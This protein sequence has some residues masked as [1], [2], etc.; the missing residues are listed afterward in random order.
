MKK[1]S[2]ILTAA[3]CLAGLSAK[4]VDSLTMADFVY[5]NKLMVAGYTGSETL[6][7][8]PVL[9][10]IS[11]SLGDFQYSR[12][13][14]SKG[15]DLAF[16]AEDGTKLASEVDTWTTSG[17]SLVWV[18]LPSMSNGTKFYMCYRLTDELAA[19][20][21]M[22]EN[23]NPWDDYVG[24]WHLSE[25]GTTGIT[26]ADSSTNALDGLTSA[27]T[28]SG[29]T[30]GKIGRARK[31]T[32]NQSNTAGQPYESGITVN[33]DNA[34][35]MDAVDS[36]VPAFAASMWIRPLQS[37]SKW[38]Y[39]IA[40]RQGDK[41]PG[42]GVQFDLDS[43]AFSPLRIYAGA[44]TDNGNYS[45]KKQNDTASPYG[46][47]VTANSPGIAQNTWSK[48]DVVWKSDGT[49]VLYVNG[50]PVTSGNLANNSPP[51]NNGLAK[52]DI[53]GAPAVTNR[54]DKGGRGLYGEMDEVR[55]RPGVPSA[56]WVKAD[57]D[58]VNNASFVTVAPKDP[59]EVTWVNAEGAAPGVT[60]VGV[61]TV[62]VSGTVQNCGDFDT[63]EIQFKFWSTAESEPESWMTITNGLVSSDAFSVTVP[64]M[65]ALTTYNYKLRAV[66]DDGETASA[67]VSGSF[68]MLAG[69][70][71]AWSDAVPGAEG[72]STVGYNSV[73]VGGTVVAL[74]DATACEIQFKVWEDGGSEPA[75]WTTITNGL[76]ASDVF[77][78]VIPGL[79]P[80][81]TYNYSLRA[82]GN[83]EPAS[84]T[85]P[86]T[87]TF[88][89]AAGLTIAATVSNVSYVSA[90]LSGSVTALGGAT[91]CA[92]QYKVWISEDAE[93][94]WT[95]LAENLELNDVF[96]VSVTN[97][98]AGTTYSYK[99]R[100]VGDDEE[101]TEVVSGT[102]TTQ[103]EPG[104]VIGSDYTH[105]F[106]DGTN[107][108]WVAN[109]FE[110]YLQF[111][112]TGYE[113]SETLTNFPVLVEVRK[114]DT[115]GFSYD[116]FYRYDGSDMTFVD[117]KGHLIPHEIDTW[118]KN[119]MSLFWVR[120]PRMNNGTTFTMCY[121]SP[122]LDPIPYAGN[123]FEKYVGVWH[124]NET[125]DGVVD[126]VDATTNNLVG[127]SHAQS[128]AYGNGRIG[129][130]RQ[131]AQ[132]P[133]PSASNGRIIVFDKNDI[134][135][136]GVG[137][138]FTYSCWSKLCD[139]S[140]GWA[141][142]VSRKVDDYSVG[143]GVQYHDN[144]ESTKKLRVYSGENGKNN[145]DFFSIENIGYSHTSWSCWTFVFDGNGPF[146]PGT[147]G[148]FHAYYNGNELSSTVGGLPLRYSIV[149][150]ENA[151]F[152]HLVLGGQQNGTG[153]LNGYLDECRYS[154]GIRS[155][156]WIKAEYVSAMQ[157]AWW[158]DAEKRFVTK[159]A[160]VGRGEESLA[161]VVVWEKGHD[162][163]YAVVDVSYAYVQFSGTVT[164]CGAGASECRIEYQLWADG[165]E[166][167]T[168]WTTLLD[169]ATAGTSFSIPV[170]GL[171]QD[172]PYKFCVRAVN[173]VVP[174]VEQANREQIGYFR[175]NGN[176][177]EAAQGELLRVDNK[178]CHR[179]RAG[180]Y[181]F[182]TP[183]YVTNVEIMVVG[184]GGAG[185][186]KVGG[187]GGG[188]GLF[189]AESFPVA[190]NATYRIQVG[191]GGNAASN[192]TAR[193][194]NG[195]NSYFARLDVENN[196]TN[197][198]M[199]ILVPG[200]GS[201][202]SYSSTA[203]IA[204]GGDG[205][206]G[207][208]GTYAQ[209]G[210]SGDG[211]YGNDGGA[212]N[213]K[214][215]ASGKSKTA[216][217]GGGGAGRGGLMATSDNWWAGGA[218][219]VG[220]VC[221]MTGETL[222]Y[223][224]GGG[225][226]YQYYTDGAS[227]TRPG[228]GG[229][230]I[231]G[232]AANVRDGIL[233]TS[234]IDNTG[235]GGGGG[236]MTQGASG[237]EI[238][239]KGGDGGDG[240]VLV[241][242]EVHGRDPISEDPRIAMTRC[243]YTPTDDGDVGTGIATIDYRA[244]WAGIQ[245]SENDIYILYSTEGEDDVAA[246]NGERI[247][248][249]SGAIGTG[250]TTFVPPEAGYTYWIRLVA[251]KD[252]SSFMYSDE[253][254]SFYVPAVTLNGAAWKNNG[255]AQVN[256]KLH[257]G[258]P[259][260]HLYCY[261]SES[262]ELLEGDSEPSGEGVHFLDLGTDMTNSTSFV[263]AASEGLDKSEVYYVRL[264]AGDEGGWK[265]ALSAEI[266]ELADAPTVIL[267]N[268]S[269]S[270]QI[271]T[272]EFTANTTILPSETTE[273]F[274][275]YSTNVKN[276]N[277]DVVNKKN[278]PH[279]KGTPNVVLGN[280]SDLPEGEEASA[281]FPLWTDVA[282]NYYVRLAI[283]SAASNAWWYSDIKEITV[284]PAVQNQNTLYIYANAN[285]KKAAYGDALQTLDYE[286]TYGGLTN[287]V[288]WD[289]K[290]YVTG[291]LAC[292]V[293]ITTVPGTYDIT[294]G[295]LDIS[296]YEDY[297]DD[298][299]YYYV[300]SCVGAKYTVTNAVFSVDIPDIV[301][302]YTGEAFDPG[303]IV[304]VLT[305][306]RNNQ[307]VTC[308]YRIGSDPWSSTIETSY[309]DAC[310]R[311][312]QF[313]AT[314]PCHEEASGTF[315]ITINPAPLSATISAEGW[316]YTGEPRAP[317]V[318]TN[319]TGL[320][321]G[322]LNPL[323]C[324]FRD[325]GGAWQSSVPSSFVQPGEYT[326]YF[327]VSASNHVTFVT[328]CTFKITGWEYKVNMDG[329][330]GLENA[331]DINVSDPGWLLRA[332]GITG[333]A[334]AEDVYGNLNAV[335]PNGLKLWQNYVIERNDLSEMLVA[336]I[337]QNCLR[338]A[339]NC[340][341]LRF[342]DA[343]ALRNTGLAVKFRVDQK[344]KGDGEF[345]EGAL[346]DKYEVNVPLGPHDPTGLYVFNMVF[347]PTNELYS[348]Q[349]SVISS[350]ATVGVMRVSSPLPNAVVA[351]PWRSMA[352][353]T[354][355]KVNVAAGDAVNPNG[356]TTGDMI[357]SYNQATTNFN[358]W[359]IGSDGAWN[360]LATVNKGGVSIA[361]P[362]NTFF[363]LGSAF[364]LV[365]SEPT[366][367][368]ATNCFYLIGRYTG[369][370]YEVPLAGGT[371]ESPGNTL[372]ANPT[373]EDIDL[374]DLAFTGSIAAGDRIVMQ[375]VAGAQ[376]TYTR[377][378]DKWGRKVMETYRGRLRQKWVE[379]GTNT[380]G[381]GFWYIRTSNEPLTIS[382]GGAK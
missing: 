263:I 276:V 233:A 13:R 300:F 103:G 380:V 15:G 284:E 175:T 121:R 170:T 352:Y 187:G 133:G 140:P 34:A 118:N 321:R 368:G 369:E 335:Q 231:G 146:E 32:T 181:I 51:I 360:G 158:N 91:S 346:T 31:I 57:Y 221:D 330:T 217:G 189:Y 315:M 115:N 261:W 324:E 337:H 174:G 14:S 309:L 240:V 114:E 60:S 85:T 214:T 235:A 132:V 162:L 283:H 89:T 99:V 33:L 227:Y 52:F 255:D 328:N 222:Y 120:L 319:V 178:F 64:G 106:D 2:L 320:V 86:V 350:V 21:T 253:I 6:A 18:K 244:Y 160:Q 28:G 38:N 373:T 78:V 333:A 270:D 41:D 367:G 361:S 131:V 56:D 376:I 224:A 303:D 81:T 75:G 267:Q 347:V 55:L 63:C 164:F 287:G 186:Y 341:E 161:P 109:G 155:A 307:P 260:T 353:A 166:S 299:S 191:Q 176:I 271:A 77:S 135:R 100:A 110:R 344:L 1:I 37:T 301:T 219:G 277:D 61:D 168:A 10:R 308:Q 147:N 69:F 20:D 27:S 72:L 310:T 29:V 12:M 216:A 184:G 314:A 196:V 266:A 157:P 329:T 124:M 142:L 101:E 163:P 237:E 167:P 141:Y 39:L 112:V 87:S 97:L 169:H 339:P 108:Y 7:N 238:Y 318:T 228:T 230:G 379:D 297:I 313:K 74:G 116:D 111:T 289:N 136:T 252:A 381:T 71:V 104:E 326:L 80:L 354:T 58:T 134:I 4:A 242:Y 207:G 113:G 257:D 102:F 251:R 327:R 342:P 316:N 357:L 90:T 93:P 351:V 50:S 338:V 152:D 232:D 286:V 138:V 35:K 211:V 79:S 84:E 130:A 19:L 46:K 129:G 262:R 185:G 151:T 265:R 358:A 59:P 45:V 302:N 203:A 366:T 92:V 356:I 325:E 355:N 159:A 291:A 359:S 280:F 48:V 305:G 296:K 226:G 76:V 210:G 193:S 44:E 172:M 201:G 88:T 323:V 264:A 49:F 254:A 105:F 365:R 209:A 165:G 223:G 5:T 22:V 126:V 127:E 274:A 372:V 213:D 349:K 363:A 236:S 156:D 205:A 182:T 206:S 54:L 345:A 68:T 285:P 204:I 25:T 250:T 364:W 245:A 98:E 30:A 83:D 212:G 218:G 199:L 298:V 65:A 95:T 331:I 294:R 107:A 171:K 117:E 382:F 192:P 378:N 375:S 17:T 248:V 180:S 269:W 194:E 220:V 123:V 24:V 377:K 336:T 143:W 247:K 16:F 177:N 70:S 306:V 73:T 273:L 278:R 295:T 259:G 190:T 144:S 23:P 66:G 229:S 334:F 43:N 348:S 202:G 234:G 96:S 279:L 42:W 208:G 137:N 312:V 150:D 195:E 148:L 67:V 343:S 249:A 154:K 119:G 183:D 9:V 304:P 275:F 149:N 215:A 122:L 332:K 322:D 153:A 340:F 246:G 370:S 139:N 198:T 225:G 282:T 26:I 371:V 179:Y 362:T 11:T 292:D 47:V 3:L 40:Q 241:S 82:V 268:A 290:P 317:E 128:K 311:M 258:A 62:V 53:G 173:E 36:L 239:W 243:S 281:S 256:Y 272:V 145:S 125:A 293:T 8:F 94:S 200:G 374:N 288:A 197:E 188:G